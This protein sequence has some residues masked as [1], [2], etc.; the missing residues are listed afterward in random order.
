MTETIL[1]ST[2]ADDADPAFADAK[3]QVLDWLD[4]HAVAVGV[5]FD[6]KPFA[7]TATRAGNTLGGLIGSTNLGWLHVQLLAVDGDMQAVLGDLKVGDQ[8]VTDGADRLRHGST[9][10]V[11][12]AAKP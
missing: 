2:I 1:V 11:V 6:S 12:K 3:S 4:Q 9:V 8:V 5:V 10:E 7:L